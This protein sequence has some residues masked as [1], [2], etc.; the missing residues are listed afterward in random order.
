[1]D[2]GQ[3]PWDRGGPGRL[4]IR[5]PEGGCDVACL[6]EVGDPA[7]DKNL[8]AAIAGETYE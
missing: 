5:S 6:H 3:G 8:K 2:S 1:M 4:R 7:T